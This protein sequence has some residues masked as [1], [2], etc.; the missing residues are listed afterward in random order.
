LAADGEPQTCSAVLSTRAGVGL[1]E[2][3][4]DDLLLLQR[5][6]YAGIGHLECNYGLG[7]LEHRVLRAPPALRLQ[8]AQPNASLRRELERIRQQVL[9]HLLQSL[10]VGRD[11]VAEIRIKVDRK[12]KLARL[13]LVAE[14]TRHHL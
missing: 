10:G 14:R 2:C 11:A 1:L 6:A 13:R 8:N 3:F 7:V 5:N 12:G 4:E 9:E